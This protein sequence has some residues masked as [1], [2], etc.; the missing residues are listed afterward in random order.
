MNLL[1]SLKLQ[2]KLLLLIAGPLIGMIFFSLILIT[3]SIDEKTNALEIQ[4]LMAFAVTN[5]ELVHEIQKERGLTSGF[6][7]SSKDGEFAQMLNPQR[8]LSNEKIQ[9][10]NAQA[11]LTTELLT[12]LG[13]SAI[14]RENS[15]ALER[16]NSVRN[17]IDDRTISASE[18]INFYTEINQSLL[19]IVA[20]IAD[21]ANSAHIKQLGFAF[22]NFVQAKENAGKERAVLSRVFGQ[23]TLDLDTLK[24]LNNLTL[25]QDVYFSEFG[26]T[27]TPNM[28]EMLATMNKSAI[29]VD[30]HRYKNLVNQQ[31]LQGGFEVSPTDWF[32]SATKRINE[33]KR[34]EDIITAELQLSSKELASTASFNSFLY[35]TL[36]LVISALCMVLAYLLI[37]RLRN[38]V[39]SLVDAL[40]YSAQNN[41]LDKDFIADSD[42]EF[43]TINIAIS[44]VFN[45]FKKVIIGISLSSEN[46]ATSSEQNAV[47]VL[48]T[49]KALE[50][51]KQQTYMI[52]TSVEEMSQS[53]A[54]VSNRTLDASNAAEEAERIAITSNKVVE[55][56][57]SQIKS[58]VHDVDSVH[59]IVAE[60]NTSSV[61]ITKVIDVIK[62]V[63]EQTNL[64]ALNAAIEAARAG[65]QGRGFAVVAD[66][67]RAL[68]KRTHEST[69][70]IEKI[71]NT[72]TTS[73]TRAF[74]VIEKCQSNTTETVKKSDE[75]KDA[76]EDIR[77]AVSSISLMT[78]QIAAATEEQAQVSAQLSQNINQISSVADESAQAAN[79]IT[80]TS[81][82]QSML[83]QDLRTLSATFCV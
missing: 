62:A 11:Q 17:Q 44:Q 68:A 59:E 23:N 72:F 77:Q 69:Q 46:L 76:F 25:L 70:Q 42:D 41:A 7:G 8:K 16:I 40:N 64:L 60:L 45:A 75:I 61:E 48:Q 18:A 2:N 29:F 35:I 13:L 47:V 15:L 65:E 27:A 9:A 38:Q 4:R 51:Q 58:V 80:E 28:V 78:T 66:E 12:K 30:V 71:I 5:T 34:G 49:S 81:K 3:D 73:T 50:N 57:A 26:N 52:A 1:N 67:V 79:E 32:E 74:E 56:S 55:Q 37:I 83:A 20:K 6:Y 21:M 19:H 53:I 14:V 54:E 31:S 63:A 10:K 43:G 33:L 36:A 82:S 39:K 22:Y 24:V